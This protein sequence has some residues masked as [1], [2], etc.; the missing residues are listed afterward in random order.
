[1]EN[2][3]ALS[4]IIEKYIPGDW[5]EDCCSEGASCPVSC[6]RGADIVPIENND[7]KGIP[8]RWISAKSL[9]AR[10]LS[11]GDI[12]IEKSGGSPIQSTGRVVFISQ[13]LLEEKSD[14]VCSNFCSAFRIKEGWNP[15]YVYYYLK[16]V[17]NSGVFFNFEGK[18]SGLKNLQMEIAF[19][20]LNIEKKSP[21]EQSAIVDTLSV[22]ERKLAVNRQINENLAG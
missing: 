12:I 13:D 7:Y 11:E 9:N 6:I 18:T 20:S 17:Y 21:E 3:Y 22:I 19:K 5:G 2:I 15:K 8:T 10:R 4:D 1:M 16:H 14:I